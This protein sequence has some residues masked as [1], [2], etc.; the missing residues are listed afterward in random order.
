MLKEI[1]ESRSKDYFNEFRKM[2]YDNQ[3]E[4]DNVVGKLSDNSFILQQEDEL[5]Q[6]RD[7]V[8]EL[9]RQFQ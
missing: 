2:M 1:Y 9:T 3:K 6:F 4:M 8:N 5:R 7:L